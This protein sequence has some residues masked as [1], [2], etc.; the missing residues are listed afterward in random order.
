V[1]SSIERE[2]LDAFA[3]FLLEANR[4][5]NLTAARDRAAVWEHIDDSLAL[6]PYVKEPLVDIGSGGGFPAIPL[7]LVTGMKMT[8]VES[9]EKKARFL[10][11]AAERFAL[12]IVVEA[13]RAE[14]AAHDPAL[15]ERFACATARAVASGPSVL[16]LTVPFLAIGGRAL[17]QRGA[18]DERE[19]RAMFDAALVLGACVRDEILLGGE[20]R[21]LLIVEKTAP[22]AARF[23]RRAGVPV[24][25]PLCLS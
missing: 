14:D 18:L 20:H 8:L 12:P 3:T 6:A 25:R 2:R 23:P 24:K 22:T 4:S 5:V 13:R 7:A 21:R 11:A 9:L 19:R 10:R 15:R 16:E 17:L 1:L